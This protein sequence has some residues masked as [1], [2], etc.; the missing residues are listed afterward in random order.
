MRRQLFLKLSPELVI[1]KR[2]RPAATPARGQVQLGLCGLRHCMPMFGSFPGELREGVSH[3]QRAAHDG[4]GQVQVDLRRLRRLGPTVRMFVLHKFAISCN[5][6]GNVSA[7]RRPT[8]AQGRCRSCAAS[9]ASYVCSTSKL[10]SRNISVKQ[11]SHTPA[12]PPARWR[13][14][15]TG[16]PAPPPPRAAPPPAAPHP[17]DPSTARASTCKVQQ[18]L[19]PPSACLSATEHRV[20]QCFPVTGP[21]GRVHVHRKAGVRFGC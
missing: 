15:S 14:A 9:A 17:P 20:A 11:E 1:S 19:K 7:A 13:R 5:V 18:C 8:V 4:A 21:V 3:V 10:S 16:S 2:R 6:R 12:A